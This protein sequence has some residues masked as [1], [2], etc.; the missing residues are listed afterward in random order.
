M[1]RPITPML[2]CLFCCAS[3]SSVAATEAPP[4]ELEQALTLRVDGD[5]TID[6]NGVPTDYA[7]K[8]ELPK[9]LAD[10]LQ[11]QVHAWR[12]DPILIDGKPAKVKTLMHVTLGATGDG[13]AMR[14]SIEAVTFPQKS[15]AIPDDSRPVSLTSDK[16][17]PPYY[18]QDELIAG[19]EARVAVQLQ[20][21]ADG[22]VQQA[23][24]AQTG[25]L[26]IKGDP[27]QLRGAIADFE[28]ASLKAARSWRFKV[29]ADPEVL[30]RLQVSDPEAYAQAMT[31]TIPIEFITT[32][33]PPDQ[34]RGWQ[35]ETRTV[36]HAAPWLQPDGHA[37]I[38]GVN[39]VASGEIAMASTQFHLTTTVVGATL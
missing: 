31:V 21:G 11:R 37:Q 36:K 25:L 13:D 34:R 39:D 8:T 20:V 29:S 1:K 19:V 5:L 22:K 24:V 26:H 15:G 27:R 17:E 35:Q 33:T 30:E 12:F 9:V 18:P 10:S 32:N 38:V 4:I 2:V 23:S 28:H 14:V 7:V 6:P 3:L 16:P